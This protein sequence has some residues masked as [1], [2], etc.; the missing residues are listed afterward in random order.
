[1]DRYGPRSA[2]L[3]TA[4]AL[5]LALGAS[6]AVAVDKPTEPGKLTLIKTAV[7]DVVA[8]KKGNPLYIREA[9]KPNVSGCTGACAKSWPAA[10]GSPTKAKDVTARTSRTKKDAPGSDERQVVLNTHPLYY[11]KNDM[12]NRPR[13]QNLPGFSLIAGNGRPLSEPT[14]SPT[15]SAKPGRSA[16]PG[17]STGVIASATARV[18]APAR[19][20]TP[21]GT[22]P[23]LMKPKDTTATRTAK[24]KPKPAKTTPPEATRTATRKPAVTTPP[25]PRRTT[26]PPPATRSRTAT[27]ARPATTGPAAVTPAPVTTRTASASASVGV[28][29]VT[30]SGGARGGAD[31]PVAVDSAAAQ[32]P[33]R[34]VSLALAAA[35]TLVAAVACTALLMRARRRSRDGRH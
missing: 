16:S 34:A 32:G 25:A 15:R 22:R 26:A 33:S 27:P 31:H 18:P 8:D 6:A 1:M 17:T 13:G 11:F 2:A 19:I 3:A 21:T 28:L 29:Q 20:A 5:L 9:D 30:P 7:G 24:P 14:T 12:P 4:A 35:T 23:P 10:L